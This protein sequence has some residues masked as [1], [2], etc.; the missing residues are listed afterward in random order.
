MSENASVVILEN[1][2]QATRELLE[3]YAGD[4]PNLEELNLDLISKP[5]E[6]YSDTDQS[7]EMKSAVIGLSNSEFSCSIC[8]MAPDPV[9]NELYQGNL[10]NPGDWIGEL[11]NQLAGRLKNNLCDYDVE[12]S[13]S[14]PISISGAQLG[15]PTQTGDSRLHVATTEAGSLALLLN[16]EIDPSAHWTKNEEQ[17]TADE[18]SL[19]LF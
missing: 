16:L 6:S 8:L 13:L 18:G 4:V 10:E 7:L 19:M 9:L 15:F 14:T 5:L 3:F 2:L 11:G 1:F 17:T 12:T